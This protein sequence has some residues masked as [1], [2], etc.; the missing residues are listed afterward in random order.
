MA[1][2]P[3]VKLNEDNCP[4]TEQL[5]GQLRGASSPEA[6]EVA[7]TLP[8]AQRARLAAF[9][10]NKSHLHTLGL[11]IASTCGRGT[12]V[13]AGGLAGGII[14]DQS[15]DPDKTLSA[16][17]RSPGSHPPKPISLAISNERSEMMDAFDDQDDQDEL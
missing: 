3:S 9:C 5:F 7:K 14:Y 17:L 12:L 4:V 10:Y 15:R 6:I 16:E 8:E 11:M 1:S 2:S 13:K